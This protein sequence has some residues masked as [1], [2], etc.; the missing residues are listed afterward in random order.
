[1]GP[2][3]LSSPI[4]ATRTLPTSFVISIGVEA[5]ITP[6]SGIP[7]IPPIDGSAGTASPVFVAE[8]IDSAG[9]A[10]SVTTRRLYGPPSG[11]LVVS[12]LARFWAMTSMR[13]RCADRP[14]EAI[15]NALNI[16]LGASGRCGGV[17]REGKAIRG[18]VIGRD[19]SRRSL[20]P[21]ARAELRIRLFEELLRRFIS[22]L[23]VGQRCH[24]GLEVDLLAAFDRLSGCGI[25]RKGEAVAFHRRLRHAARDGARPLC[26]QIEGVFEI[27][28]VRRAANDADGHCRID[29]R[30][31]G[32]RESQ[33]SVMRATPRQAV[34]Q[35][36]SVL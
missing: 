18:I 23:L 27:V 33:P 29:G 13:T 20:F 8:E 36:V 7:G 3:D 35:P 11:V 22:E 2:S 25:D 30:R 26:A 19:Q 34:D 16:G 31:A 21:D 10:S 12:A 24:L 4:D 1:M 28:G 32:G 15:A 6:A 5:T 9:V 14:L 17:G